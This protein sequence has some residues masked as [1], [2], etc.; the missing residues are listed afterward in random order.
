[1][2]G[3]SF[4][5]A[6]FSFG[7]GIFMCLLHDFQMSL[8]T[9]LMIQGVI[10]RLLLRALHE[11]EATDAHSSVDQAEQIDIDYCASDPAERKEGDDEHDAPEFTSPPG[12]SNKRLE[13]VR[14]CER[15][16]RGV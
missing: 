8:Q 16:R 14:S 6:L 12:M 7:N 1:M 5:H 13:D 11:P 4:Y 2:S 10:E 9:E 15:G 3:T